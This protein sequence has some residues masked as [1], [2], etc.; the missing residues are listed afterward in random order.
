MK[1]IYVS[2]II[3]LLLT[4]V[5]LV[6][7]INVEYKYAYQHKQTLQVFG[8]SG[9]YKIE[10]KNEDDQVVTKLLFNK[11]SFISRYIVVV[12]NTDSTNTVSSL[13]LQIPIDCNFIIRENLQ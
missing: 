3:L 12:E 1:T 13:T 11:V 10:I 5:G 6:Y 2:S 4:V 8:G 9:K 7:Y